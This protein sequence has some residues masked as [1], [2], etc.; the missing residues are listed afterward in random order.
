MT[1]INLFTNQKQTHSFIENK[2]MVKR[3]KWGG[4]VREFGIATY[5][6]T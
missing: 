1:Q 2:L 3:G 5:T 4:I 6:S